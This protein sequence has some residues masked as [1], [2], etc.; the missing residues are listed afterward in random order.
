MGAIQAQIRT[1]LAAEAGL[2]VLGD[3]RFDFKAKTLR[4]HDMTAIASLGGT[5]SVLVAF[6]FDLGLIEAICARVTAGLDIPEGEEHLYLRETA[7]ETANTIL[8]LC[9]TDLGG[10]E[11]P[12]PLSPPVIIEDA[13]SIHRPRMAVF[14]TMEARTERGALTVSVVGPHDLFD[15]YLNF[16]GRG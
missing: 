15:D 6:S 8:G 1:V 4:L 16:H 14:A 9:T 12:I 7:A 13:R 10:H 3:E 5:I 2:E 11:N